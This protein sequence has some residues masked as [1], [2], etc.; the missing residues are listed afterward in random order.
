MLYSSWLAGDPLAADAVKID[1]ALL[2]KKLGRVRAAL[3]HKVERGE[4]G[5][6]AIESRYLA[7]RERAGARLSEREAES[8]A[9]DISALDRELDH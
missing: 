1:S 3:Q 7:L 4:S 6:D 8:L 2:Q 9:R 5:S